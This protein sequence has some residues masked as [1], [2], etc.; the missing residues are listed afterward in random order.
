M[1]VARTNAQGRFAIR[2]LPPDP[3]YLGVAVEYL[4]EGEFEDPEFLEQMRIRAA[5]VALGDGQRKSVNLTL[6]DRD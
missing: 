1:R 5:D 2:K 3:R 6:S 4:E